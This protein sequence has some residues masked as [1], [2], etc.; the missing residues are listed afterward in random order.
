MKKPIQ[1]KK[2]KYDDGYFDDC[3]ICQAMKKAGIKMERHSDRVSNDS[4]WEEGF[5]AAKVTPKDLKGLKEAF[6][7]AKEQGVIVG[8]EWLEGGEGGE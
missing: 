3:P 2:S 7:K 4:I 5:S 1:S 6:K 8:G